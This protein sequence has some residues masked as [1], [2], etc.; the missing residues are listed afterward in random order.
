[1]PQRPQL[2]LSLLTSTQRPAQMV[3]PEGQAQR[4]ISQ[5]CPVPQ[6][7][8]Q[9]P[10]FIASVWVFT[11]APLQAFSP[12][13]HAHMPE[14]Q[15]CPVPQ[16]VPQLPQL[17]LSDCVS[18]QAIEAP[19]PHTAR[20]AAQ[21]SA[22]R[23]AVQLWP[24]GHTVPQEPQLVALVCAS[25][26]TSPQSI[27]PEGQPTS[28]GG[29]ST[30][31]SVGRTSAGGTSAG[32]TSARGTSAGGASVGGTS[33]GGTSA[34]GTSV[35]GLSSGGVVSVGDTSAGGVSVCGASSVGVSLPPVSVGGGLPIG[36]ESPQATSEN[37][38]QATASHRS[39]GVSKKPPR[40]GCCGARPSG[41]PRSL[42]R[43]RR[44]GAAKR[45][46]AFACGRNYTRGRGAYTSFAQR[47]GDAPWRPSATTWRDS[48]RW[49]G[50]TG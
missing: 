49:P 34:G 28:A 42:R 36:L 21:G 1:M 16:T 12:I 38:V 17:L 33:E 43:P 46:R 32:G 48:L 25:T 18:T 11:Q 5:R 37:A 35:W 2:A 24:V 27:W 9:A 6:A 19:A 4:P 23:P 45:R 50:V 14:T 20:G 15:F 44:A 39:V 31:T 7:V 30:G 22:Q 26:Q 8:P 10:Q 40:S 41:S 47:K 29:M 13:G 3:W